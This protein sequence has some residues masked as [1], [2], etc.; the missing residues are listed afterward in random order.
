MSCRDDLFKEARSFPINVAGGVE[1]AIVIDATPTCPL[2]ISQR[3]IGV[4]PSARAAGFGGWKEPANRD[5]VRVVP[6][7]FVRQ[8]RSEHAP[9]CIKDA[10]GQ[11]G[12]RKSANV[13][14]F[15]RNQVVELNQSGAQLVQKV[16]PLVAGLL[17]QPRNNDP[18]LTTIATALHLAR[19]RLLCAPEFAGLGAIPA[20][21]GD[22][23]AIR[24]DRQR[25]QAY[26]NAD[27]RHNRPIGSRR[28]RLLSHQADV[29]VST[30]LTLEGRALGDTFQW[31]VNDCLDHADLRN[32]DTRIVKRNPLRN[33][34][35][36]RVGFL[37]L[38]LRET[39]LLVALPR[40]AKE[41]LI[42][43]IKIAQ[44]L[45]QQLRV[46]LAQP[47]GRGLLFQPSQLCRQV[48]KRKR[49][50][51]FAVVIALLP[52]RPVP[53]ESPCARKLI[54][55]PFLLSSRS[56]AIAIGGLDRS[57]HGASISERVFY[58]N[59]LSASESQM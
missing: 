14:I 2:A 29:P 34:E 44:R 11:L 53:D 4:D 43:T 40:A 13:Q 47:G 58:Y 32:R 37:G 5:Q 9:R 25:L 30:R 1:I 24:Q 21:V 10:L 31:S 20:W 57:V 38:E 42:R 18:R 12:F 52:Q 19:K 8:H 7:S 23:F 48:R 15:N 26:I 54:E 45:L 39:L 28:V 59:V 22:R 3:E 33:T 55:H 16:V 49:F 46:H 6:I 35:A 27:V 50:A 41:M 36:R 17:V 51:G 56:K